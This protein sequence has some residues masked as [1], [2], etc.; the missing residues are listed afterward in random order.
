MSLFSGNWFWV[1]A[2]ALGLAVVMAVLVLAPGAV[3][4]GGDYRR[5]FSGRVGHGMKELLLFVDV[6]RLFRA[7]LLLCLVACALV[8]LLTGSLFL[9]LVSVALLGALPS[10]LIAHLGAQRRKQFARQLPDAMMLIGGAVRAG[11]SMTL[12]L[13]QMASELPAPGGQEFD[14]LLREL[15]LG[16]TLDDALF[17]LEKRMGCDD[18]R[19]FGAAVRIANESG[20]NLAETLERLADTMRK[21]MALEDKIMALTS[22]GR[23]QGWVMVVLPLGV[24]A[25]LFAIQPDAMTPLIHSWQGWV[26]CG[27]VA[28]LEVV[29]LLFIR[30]IMAIDI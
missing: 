14:L 30:R 6:D 4:A 26:T 20:G 29:G 10:L 16:V 8:W 9:V 22:Q 28:I 11:A 19:L 5:H 2:V 3:K 27:V 1:G 13:R 18:L 25:A 15:R 23:M 17:S 12:A 24:G 7:N 21:K